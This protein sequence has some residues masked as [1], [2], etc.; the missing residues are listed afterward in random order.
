VKP[1]PRTLS[2]FSSSLQ[3]GDRRTESEEA[4]GQSRTDIPR[5]SKAADR[6]LGQPDC[7]EHGEIKSRRH[8]WPGMAD[9]VR[10]TL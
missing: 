9:A 8:H 7:D 3:H 1:Y 5:F 4:G 2:R 10:I 6:H